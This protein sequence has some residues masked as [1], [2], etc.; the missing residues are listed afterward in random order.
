MGG[1]EAVGGSG[2]TASG[3]ATVM[4]QVRDYYVRFSPSYGYG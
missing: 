2:I 3:A 4:A 1:S